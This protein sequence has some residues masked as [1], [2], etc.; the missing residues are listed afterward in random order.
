MKLL[1]NEIS[2]TEFKIFI[3]RTDKTENK[4]RDILNVLVM[5]RNAA[6]DITFRLFDAAKKESYNI[7]HYLV[8]HKEYIALKNYTNQ[9]LRIIA[10]TYGVGYTRITDY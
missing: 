9:C 3:Q 6:S 5:Y 10:D 2:E 1:K 4:K 8:F 7:E